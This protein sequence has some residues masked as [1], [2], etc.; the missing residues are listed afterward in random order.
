MKP[1]TANP[2]DEKGLRALA[3]AHGQGH[4]F[5]FWGELNAA[6]RSALLE[7]LSRIDFDLI[8][9][10]V[11]ESAG[12]PPGVQA[13]SLAP[14]PIVRVPRTDEE[15]R[16]EARARERGA[17]LLRAGKVAAFVVAG[18][19]G[20]RLGFD[21]PKGAF[22]IGPLTGRTLFRHHAEKVLAT[23]RR[24]GRTVPWYVMTSES[25]HEA[26]LRHFRE[27]GLYGLREGDVRF[28]QQEMIPAVDARGRFFLESKGK[29]F[30]SPNGHGGSLKALHDSGALRE[31][32]E[33]G[34]ELI[35]YFQ[36]DNPLVV[37]CDPVFLGH[38]SLAGADMSCKVVRKTGP[39]EKV[40]VIGLQDGK[41]TVIEYS[42]LPE[43]EARATLPDGS[44][45]YWAGSIAIH[46]LSVSFVE[47]LNRGGFNLPYHRAEKSVPYTDESGALQK[48]S[49]KNGIK[50]ETFVFDALGLAR[51][52]VT[53]EVRR[54]EEFSPVKNARGED[55]PDKARQ[56]MTQLYLSW[57][58]ACGAR[59]ERGPDGSFPGHVELSPLGAL[60]AADLRGRVM[61]GMLVSP[62]FVL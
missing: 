33:R 19:Q 14:A 27:S 8:G 48:P 61:P 9:R 20:T 23:S 21:G 50:F 55:S 43:T 47:E 52:A 62:G 51:R 34:I 7:Q 36:V 26:T 28:F 18:G 4:V 2:T 13:G 58:E 31:M 40:G 1:R 5:R 42:D 15:R 59:V 3:E 46:V 6:E 24:H 29:V 41:L 45:K 32:R 53:L 57:L 38:H 44:L 12:P 16:D 49:A 39:G 37:M 35:F 25:N 60:D 17:E 56:D 30:T 22:V 54:E 10:L 11:A